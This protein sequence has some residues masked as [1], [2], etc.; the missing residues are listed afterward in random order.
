M[1]SSILWAFCWVKR[2]FIRHVVVLGDELKVVKR[3][4][5]TNQEM[6][7]SPNNWNLNRSGV[8]GTVNSSNTIH[9][10]IKKWR[11]RVIDDKVEILVACSYISNCNSF[12]AKFLKPYL[13]WIYN[14]YM[15]R[16]LIIQNLLPQ[17]LYPM[18][19]QGIQHYCNTGD[20]FHPP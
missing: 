2:W 7:L 10:I 4:K 14:W 12:W 8:I 19:N 16:F 13:S 11:F 20:I 6:L 18:M 3:F 15:K 5:T 17:N 1:L 9:S